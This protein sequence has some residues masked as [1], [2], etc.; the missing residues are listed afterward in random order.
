MQTAIMSVTDEELIQR[1]CGGDR[2]A[3]GLLYERYLDDIYQYMF[4][5]VGNTQ[6]SEDLT[7]K[8]FLKIWEST[9]RLCSEEPIRNF[10][11]WI[12]RISH[13]LVVDHYRS[14]KETSPLSSNE[15]QYP[16]GRSTEEDVES[17]R[18]RDL[19]VKAIGQLNPQDQEIIVARFINQLSHAETAEIIRKSEGHVRVLQYRALKK[20]RSIMA[21]KSYG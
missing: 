18:E 6:D 5:R 15:S 3:F 21:E 1:A 8:V 4:Y 16:A 19:L 2:Q 17:L 14:R 13:N 12:Y 10:R 9:P 11:A 20:L 7:E